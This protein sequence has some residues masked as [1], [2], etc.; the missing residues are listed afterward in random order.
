MKLLRQAIRKLILEEK[1]AGATDKIQQGLDEIERR[2]LF[3]VVEPD[4][5]RGYDIILHEAEGTQRGMFEV[6]ASKKCKATYITTWTKINPEFENTG[7]GAV[8]YDVAIEYATKIGS[9]LTCDRDS[10]SDEA[11]RMWRYYAMSADYEAM[12]LDTRSGDFTPENILD[13]CKQKIFHRDT[14]IPKGS[15]PNTYKEEFM[16]SPFTK[17]YRKKNITTIPCLG[18]RYSEDV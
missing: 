14:G 16:A 9:Y 13:D 18:D 7:I 2:N 12:Q 5:S 3:I 4:G 15:D 17:A 11:K 10:V 8:L 6:S 1:C